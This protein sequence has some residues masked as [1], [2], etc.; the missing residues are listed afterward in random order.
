MQMQLNFHHG[1]LQYNVIQKAIDPGTGEATP[2]YV[3]EELIQLSYQGNVADGLASYLV[4]YLGNATS[5]YVEKQLNVL[6]TL[7]I[8]STKG[9]RLFRHALRKSNNDEHL[10][11]AA[12]RG[13]ISGSQLSSPS[14]TNKEDQIRNLATVSLVKGI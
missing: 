7:Q 9:S 3:Y 4:S 5:K 8:V 13:N 10:R 12:K 6:K 14:G 1:I 11:A 2:G